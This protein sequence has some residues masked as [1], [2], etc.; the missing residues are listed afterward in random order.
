ML[1]LSLSPYR[2]LA[3]WIAV[4]AANRLVHGSGGSSKSAKSSAKKS[5]AKAQE[6]SEDAAKVTARTHEHT[7]VCTLTI[8]HA[9]ASRHTRLNFLALPVPR[10]TMTVLFCYLRDWHLP[11]GISQVLL[12]SDTPTKEEVASV[13]KTVMEASTFLFKVKPSRQFSTA[14]SSCRKLHPRTRLAC[15]A[16]ASV[17]PQ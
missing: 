11:V 17:Y 2:Y 5:P 7:Q 1:S 10:G 16:T 12:G 6:W 8:P 14:S 4:D 9:E 15:H 3:C 13:E